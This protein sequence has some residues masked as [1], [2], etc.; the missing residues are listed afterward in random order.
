M[1]VMFDNDS[2]SLS[3]IALRMTEEYEYVGLVKELHNLH[4][5][6]YLVGQSLS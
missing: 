3:L 4:R 2:C 6:I 5:L 1:M